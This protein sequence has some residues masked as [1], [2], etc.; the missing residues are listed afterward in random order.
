MY[1]L[2]ENNTA[3]KYPYT[4]AQLR[5]DNPDTSFSNNPNAETLAKYGVANVVAT[6]RPEYDSFQYKLLEES[7]E[8]IDNIW[9]QRWTLVELTAAERAQRLESLKSDIVDQVQH[10]LDSFAR[11]RNYDGI[12]SAC[13]YATDLVE[14]FRA[15]GQY[16]VQ[17]RGATWS[18][19]YS[20]LNDVDAGNRPI[21]A[22]YEEIESELPELVWP[23]Q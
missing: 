2:I 9:Q 21:P 8:F 14:K 16:C 18:K 1:A 11:T 10:R 19:I 17:A 20:I 12:M 6:A 23:N 15:E 4:I 22:G 13:T 7:P 5:M 3:K